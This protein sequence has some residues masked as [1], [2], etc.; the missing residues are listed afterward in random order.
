MGSSSDS[1]REPA[2]ERHRRAAQRHRRGRR[3]AG[4]P[5]EASR[6]GRDL[7]DLRAHHPPEHDRRRPRPLLRPGQRD[8]G[9][10]RSRAAARQRHA[11][12][13]LRLP[14][15]GHDLRN[16][17]GQAVRQL[18]H[19]AY[20][21]GRWKFRPRTAL[22]YD[23]TLA[24]Q[25]VPAPAE[26]PA[27][28][29][30]EL[31]ARAG[32]L[33][34]RTGSSPTASPC[35]L[36]GGWGASFYENTR[37][38]APQF[39]SVIAQAELQWF[40]AASPG[41][42]NATDLGLALSSIALGYTRDF[43][44]SYLG[45]YLHARIAAICV[46]YLFAGRALATLEGGVGALEYP[47][48]SS[49]ATADRAAR[50]AVHRRPRRRDA[51]RR[52]PLH[53]HLRRST[54]RS[55]TRRTSA[56]SG[57]LESWARF[58]RVMLRACMGAV[59]G[60]PRRSLVHVEASVGGLSPSRRLLVLRRLA[61]RNNRM[62]YSCRLRLS[63][64][65]CALSLASGCGRSRRTRAPESARRRR[66]ARSGPGDV[67]DVPSSARRTCRRL[68][69]PARRHDR[70]S[71]PRSADRRRP[72]AAADRGA[73][74]EG[75][76]RREDPLDAAGHARR[77]AV[78]LEEGQR[79]RRRSEA[80]SLPWTEGMK[81]VDAIS[82][83]GGLTSSPTAITSASRASSGEARPSRRPSAS[84]TSPTASSSDVP[85]QAGDTIKVDQ[86][87]F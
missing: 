56:T 22:I 58:A 30:R 9:R 33:R 5:A 6:R 44:N 81:L 47:G 87:V 19:Q 69:R 74:Q 53:R 83:S 7:R 63:P 42:A 31:D 86:R 10:R 16:D 57:S 41:I 48:R 39:D 15:H 35:G 17:D 26:R 20:T 46:Q 67:F 72:R 64:L 8:R 29:L 37:A 27:T 60:L 54:P 45:S 24:V 79:R 75:A 1:G 21:R 34:A 23:A 2:A 32:A 38:A 84:T 14:V 82:L 50:V 55:A 76:H 43:Q 78:Q 18:T 52:V 68:S 71:L 70:L 51:L 4:H 77:Q 85:L 59:R 80:G 28:L 12:L 61:Q 11:R 62:K 3:A 40:L 25:L 13:A 49:S 65:R 36:D 73:H 66:R